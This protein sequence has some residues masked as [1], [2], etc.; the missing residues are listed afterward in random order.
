MSKMITSAE[1]LEIGLVNHRIADDKLLIDANEMASHIA[2]LP[3]LSVRMNKARC[4]AADQQ[5]QFRT[6]TM[7]LAMLKQTADAME[8]ASAFREKRDPVFKVSNRSPISKTGG[9]HQENDRGNTLMT[10][11]ESYLLIFVASLSLRT[12]CSRT[13]LTIYPKTRGPSQ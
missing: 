9:E 3:P 13:K 5:T 1:A 6:E 2:S 7:A 8:A 4:Q 12:H 11:E 10:E